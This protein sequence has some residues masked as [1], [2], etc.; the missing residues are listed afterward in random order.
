MGRSTHQTTWD[1][2]LAHHQ[3]KDDTH[4]NTTGQSLVQAQP[5]VA[6]GTAQTIHHH[7][8]VRTLCSHHMWTKKASINRRLHSGTDLS[9]NQPISHRDS[10]NT[11]HAGVPQ[12]PKTATTRRTSHTGSLRVMETEGHARHPQTAEEGINVSHPQNTVSSQPRG[13]STEPLTRRT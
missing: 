5:L 7:P 8:V 3:G 13:N 6:Q 10:N 12:R 4:L 9:G 11:T 1:R 2:S